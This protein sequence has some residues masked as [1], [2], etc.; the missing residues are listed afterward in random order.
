[1]G[2]S[3]AQAGSQVPAYE[4]LVD[5]ANVFLKDL[6]C[7]RM[8][9]ALKAVEFHQYSCLCKW[10]SNVFCLRCTIHKAYSAFIT[11]QYMKSS[12]WSEL[13]GEKWRI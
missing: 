8:I 6:K 11:D 5:T 7:R 1:M 10:S 13:W 12:M 2:L 4:I 3:A 9:K